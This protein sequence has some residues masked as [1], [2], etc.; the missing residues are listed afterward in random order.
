MPQPIARKCGQYKGERGDARDYECP[1]R[2]RDRKKRGQVIHRRLY[3]LTRSATTGIFEWP[4]IQAKSRPGLSE[5]DKDFE[6]VSP[7]A[8]FCRVDAE[9]LQ[10]LCVEYTPSGSFGR[11]LIPSI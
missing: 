3:P 5:F 9:S 8:S 6:W 4:L 11:R 7:I 1:R 10:C 2:S